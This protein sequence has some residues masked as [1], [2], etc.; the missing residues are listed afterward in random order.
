LPGDFSYR[1][2]GKLVRGFQALALAI[3]TSIAIG[4]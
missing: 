4:T 2:G 1:V 3:A